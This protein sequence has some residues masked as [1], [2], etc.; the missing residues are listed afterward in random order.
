[1]GFNGDVNTVGGCRLVTASDLAALTDLDD[2]E[3]VYLQADALTPETLWRLRY[4]AA[5]ATYPWQ[6]VGGSPVVA[7]VQTTDSLNATS[8]GN[9]R[10]ATQSGLTVVG[11]QIVLPA[12]GY[13][14]ARWGAMIDGPAAGSQTAAGLTINGV[15]PTASTDPWIANYDIRFE[16]LAG[17]RRIEVTGNLTV[18]MKFLR[19]DN[20]G[21]AARFSKRWLEITPVRLG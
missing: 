15:D 12:A 11:P 14:D 7:Q 1:M 2:G 21:T 5:I 9:Y 17:Q 18:L 20:S 8:F 10:S 13:Y 19:A 6:F 4:N 16:S 3:E